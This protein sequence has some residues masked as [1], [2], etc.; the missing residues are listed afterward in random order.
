[1]SEH[2][3]AK[4]IELNPNMARAYGNRG[5]VYNRTGFYKKALADFNTA[6]EIKP[7][8][9][10]LYFGRWH[11]HKKL[12]HKKKAKADLK[13]SAELGFWK[14]KK[15]LNKESRGSII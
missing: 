11:A 1:M 6:I 2:E 5:A 14:A 4:A 13:K 7:M 10:K 3:T 9:A 12:G 15:K 8:G